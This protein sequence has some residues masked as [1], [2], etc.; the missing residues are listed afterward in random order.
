MLVDRTEE[1]DVIGSR[2]VLKNK[3][4]ADGKLQRR[5]ARL[6]AQGFSQCPGVHYSQTFAPIARLSTVRL[7]TSLAARHNCTVNQLDVATAY[8]N[9]EMEEI[10]HIRPP[11]GL[12]E[13]LGFLVKDNR[14]G[15]DI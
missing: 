13:I 11:K 5:K 8:L 10:I 14:Y 15:L 9:G 2:M 12:E 7:L 1:M 4:S 3:F 6:V